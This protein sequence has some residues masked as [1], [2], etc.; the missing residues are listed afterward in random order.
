MHEFALPPI[1]PSTATAADAREHLQDCGWRLLGTG[2]WSWVFVAPD[3]TTVARVAPWDPAY[4]LHVN[5]CLKHAG[6]P[7]LP[8]MLAAMPLTGEGYVVVM[9]RLWPCD[10]ILAREFCSALGITN[11]SGYDIA[12]RRRARN[13]AT[14]VRPPEPAIAASEVLAS[15]REIINALLAQGAATLPFWGGSD[16]RPGNLMCDRAGTI[17]VIDPI[18]VQGKAILTAIQGGDREALRVISPDNLRAFL[19]IPVFAPGADAVALWQQLELLLAQ[20]D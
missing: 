16:I 14:D 6:H 20:S 1:F 15:L 17:K 5:N 10:E 13:A 9:E 11:D 2:D 7:H 3:E 8:H 4:R 19:T 18:F 12:P